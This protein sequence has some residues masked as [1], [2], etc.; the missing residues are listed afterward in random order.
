MKTLDPSHLSVLETWAGEAGAGETLRLKV[1]GGS[2]SPL[3]RSGDW[4][5]L[6][7]VPL[8]DC[9][10]GDLVVLRVANGLLVHRLLRLPALGLQ[11]KG[12]ANPFA[13]VLT[14]EVKYLGRACSFHRDSARRD[15]AAPGARRVAGWVAILSWGEARLFGSAPGASAAG[16]PHVWKRILFF[17]LRTAIFILSAVELW[18]VSRGDHHRAL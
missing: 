5:E 15:L 12:D 14:S 17:P 9:R 8:Q 11:T 3:L 2:M 18:L 16:Q 6:S 1:Q 4:V 13:D 7:P 10:P